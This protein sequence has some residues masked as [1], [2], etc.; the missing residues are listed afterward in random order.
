MTGLVRKATLLAVCGLL[1][2]AAT[3]LAGVPDP[4]H[5]TKPAFIKVVGYSGTTPDS[6]GTFTV[7][8]RDIGNFPVVNS[9]VVIDFTGT[10]DIKL[11]NTQP[12]GLDCVVGPPVQK[13][14]WARTNASGVATFTIVG[15][16]NN[17]GA[18]AGAGL[19]GVT[20]KADYVTIGVATA[21]VFDENGA[22]P[23]NNGVTA[24]D[25]VSLLKDWGSGTYF[26]RS[27]F[28]LDGPPIITAADFVPWL[29]CW[30]DGTSSS[31]CSSTYCAQ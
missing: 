15:A 8:V 19:N 24:A 22:I 20:I 2:M 26:G 14:V 31:G 7:T 17:T 25:F 28:A 4:A 13:D 10:A 1:V 3:A 21:V 9:L 30:G 6:R 18:S 11:C 27:D 5:C 29:K 16:C 23:G 12:Q